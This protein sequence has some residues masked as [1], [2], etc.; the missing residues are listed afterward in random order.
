MTKGARENKPIKSFYPFFKDDDLLC[1]VRTLQT[2]MRVTEQLRDGSTKPSPL[3]LGVVKPHLPITS[4]TISGWLR[5]VFNRAG[6]VGN[7]VAH[8][9]QLPQSP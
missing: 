6:I 7:F 8:S 4:S 2:Y 1:P 3:F 5:E 9:T